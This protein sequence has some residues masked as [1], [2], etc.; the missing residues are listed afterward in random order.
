VRASKTG[1][2]C[3]DASSWRGTCAICLDALPFENDKQTFYSCCCKRICTVCHVECR[4]HDERCPLCRAPPPKSAGE[5]LR[6]LEKHAAKGN[7]E[8]RVMLGTEYSKVGSGHR[9]DLKRAAQLFELAA[10]QGHAFAQFKLGLCYKTGIGVEIDSKTAAR[11]LRRAADQGY[12]L[13]QYKLGT[14]F[15]YGKGV[16]QSHDEA[17][18]W[19]RL[20]AAQGDKDALYYLGVCYGNGLGAPRDLDKALRLFK[21]AAAKGHA[22]AASEV[23]KLEKWLAARSSRPA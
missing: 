23:E 14:A 4:Q 3:D 22:G 12:P 13:A 10:A 18:K 1:A 19:Y 16:A 9:Q 21:R 5:W 17:V 7:A 2:L 6:R 20:A 11:W 8:A 15:Y